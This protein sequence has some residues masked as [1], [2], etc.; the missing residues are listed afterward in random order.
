[1][2][3]ENIRIKRIKSLIR[4]NSFNPDDVFE[5]H[6]VEPNG[7]VYFFDKLGRACKLTPKEYLVIEVVKGE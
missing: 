3:I 5:V 6:R 1:M 2:E 4:T 7:N